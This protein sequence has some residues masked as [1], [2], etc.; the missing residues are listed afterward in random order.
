ECRGAE[1]GNSADKNTSVQEKTT[2][3][4]IYDYV[5]VGAG[6]AGCVLANKLSANPAI[7]VLLIEAGPADDNPLIHMP[8][9]LGKLYTV[10]ATTYFYDVQRSAGKPA[11]ESWLRGRMLGGS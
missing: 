9:G 1:R 5:V 7:S 8:R 11:T 10:G 6:S 4:D 2:M 3:A